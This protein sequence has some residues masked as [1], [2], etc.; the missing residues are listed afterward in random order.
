MWSDE[1]L[2]VVNPVEVCKPGTDFIFF[3]TE[4]TLADL[5][6]KTKDIEVRSNFIIVY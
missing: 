3:V 4:H 5:E 1:F 6:M 2:G